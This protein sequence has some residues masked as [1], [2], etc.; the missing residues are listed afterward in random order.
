MLLPIIPFMEREG[1]CGPACLK[2]VLNYYEISKTE[3]YLIELSGCMKEQGL[4]GEALLTTA[5]HCGLEGKIQ[6]NS[7]LEDLQKYINE[8]EMPIIV[9]WFP[10]FDGHYSVAVGIDQENV[11]LVDPDLG[12]T[13]ALRRDLFQRLWF[14]FP[15]EYIQKPEDLI[16]RRMIIL[17]PYEDSRVK[18]REKL[19]LRGGNRRSLRGSS[20]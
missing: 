13:R 11:Y 3:D 15:G 8:R 2:M 5:H 18:D 19:R 12:Y 1:C 10:D 14:D 6:D 20:R 17:H 16:L 9:N 7:T 4:P